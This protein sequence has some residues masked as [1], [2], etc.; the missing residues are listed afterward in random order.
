MSL[1]F[2]TMILNLKLQFRKLWNFL[3]FLS[4]LKNCY[5]G[6][7]N[8]RGGSK[9]YGIHIEA[10]KL[11]TNLK[12]ELPAARVKASPSKDWEVEDNDATLMSL[13][14]PL[15]MTLR[16]TH[17]KFEMKGTWPEYKMKLKI[18]KAKTPGKRIYFKE[19][20]GKKGRKGKSNG[21]KTRKRLHQGWR[22]EFPDTGAKVPDRGAK[23]GGS[24]GMLPRGNFIIRRPKM[25]SLSFSAANNRNS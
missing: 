18:A 3:Y 8:F 2:R 16:E 19:V 5:G 24:G 14:T 22:Q 9:S 12:Y 25:A 7:N 20:V 4:L 10:S 1:P 17:P 11:G 13:L 23:L 6:S 15:Y 21:N